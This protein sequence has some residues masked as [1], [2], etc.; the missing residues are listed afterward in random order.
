MARNRDNRYHK[1]NI[2]GAFVV[3]ILVLVV[4]AWAVS[5]TETTIKPLILKGIEFTVLN[6]F[7]SARTCFQQLVDRYPDEPFGYFYLAATRQAEMLD[8][9]DFSD[10]SE[11]H[12]YL[13]L[14]ID[15]CRAKQQIRP[16]DPWLYFY[17]GSA[18]LYRSFVE[19]KQHRWWRAYQSAVTGTHRLEQAIRL[20]STLYDAYLGVGSFKYWKSSKAGFLTWIRFFSDE[21]EQG[22]AM[23]QKAIEKG[24]FVSIVGRNQLVWMLMDAG[25]WEEALRL[26]Q[27]NYRQYPDSRFFLWTLAETYR[28]S[29]NEEQAYPLYRELLQRARRQPSN[30]HYNEVVCLVHLAEID[31]QRKN[32]LR[33]DSLVR[34]IGK[35]PLSAAVRQRLKKKLELATEIRRK[36]REALA[37]SRSVAE[38]I[39]FS[40]LR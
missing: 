33:A 18:Y 12:H 8:R 32:Y 10:L 14:C 23:V 36:C 22:L 19:N 35:L 1:W 16:N 9:E 25:R 7:D 15:K 11:F 34:E 3:L 17:E 37:E 29:G 30:N 13:Q 20:D 24:E 21:R 27:E 39:D 38:P 31:L 26:A 5:P 40:R 28:K 6:R 4:H 2:K